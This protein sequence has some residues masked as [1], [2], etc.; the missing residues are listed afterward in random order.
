ME[1][2]FGKLRSLDIEPLGS[3]VEEVG[4]SSGVERLRRRAE[5]IR[6]QW[7]SEVEGAEVKEPQPD[8]R[9]VWGGNAGSVADLWTDSANG[10]LA[11][12]KES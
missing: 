8:G 7:T 4:P 3:M 6:R 1:P 11:G 12:K 5:A 2:V 9:A 10:T